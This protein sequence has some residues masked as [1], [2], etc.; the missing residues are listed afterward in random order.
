MP[1]SMFGLF[2]GMGAHAL[3]SR[4][5]GSAMADRLIVSNETYSAEEMY[6]LGIVHQLAE[7]GDVIEACRE[8]IRKSDRRHAGLVGSR[9]AM[10]HAWALE[11]DEL[12]RIT[13]MWADTALLLREQDL[14]VLNRQI[15]RASCRERG[16]KYV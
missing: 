8:F 13:E 7:P 3:L 14:Q 12:N 6:E 15:G 5:I 1:E 11:L 4:K 9:R 10:K 2:P 16:C